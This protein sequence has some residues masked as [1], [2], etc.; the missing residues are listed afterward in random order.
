MTSEGYNVSE[1]VA[2][3]E[4]ASYLWQTSQQQRM[5]AISLAKIVM[6]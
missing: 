1:N 3:S 5:A 2:N 4:I 6:F